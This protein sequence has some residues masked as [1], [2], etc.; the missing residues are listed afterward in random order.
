M[1]LDDRIRQLTDTMI[2]EIHG[3]LE[4]AMQRVL[5][6]F[7][8]LAADE[9]D[10]GL[11]EQRQQLERDRDSAVAEAQERLARD[12]DSALA[13]LQER[14]A[15]EHE[16]TLAAERGEAEAR[17]QA[18]LDEQAARLAAEHESHVQSV[19]EELGQ[20]HERALAAARSAGELAGGAALA[21]AVAHAEE[22]Q[23]RA[24]TARA[25]AEEQLDQAR[26]DLAAAQAEM[27]EVRQAATSAELSM[28]FA[29]S[30]HRNQ[31]LACTDRMVMAFRELDGARS[32]TEV[33]TLLADKAAGEA[34]RSAILIVAGSTLRGWVLRG[35]GNV[36]P[37]SLV[38]PIEPYTVFGLATSHH[39]AVSTAE[40]P[41]GADGDPLSKLLDAPSGCAG[42]AVPIAVGG[43]IVAILYADD[44]GTPAPIVPSTWPELV[45]ILARHAG[46]CLEVL[47]LTRSAGVAPGQEEDD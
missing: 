21:A 39:E 25:E 13:E 44:G 34:G 1:S 41:V 37:T 24:E 22:G 28:G 15:R 16:T 46:R 6:D 3:P 17:H 11:A 19:R 35:L 18:A 32:L 23:H 7:T 45:E 42:L 8:R 40:A 38:V 4:E 29:Q 36:D 31:E 10:A 5:G 30:A 43:R 2:Q 33:L 14:L 12:R 20:T 47:T 26:R 27:R 9:R